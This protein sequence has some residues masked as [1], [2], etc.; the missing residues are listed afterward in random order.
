MNSKLPANMLN[1]AFW[2]SHDN[3]MNAGAVKDSHCK[4]YLKILSKL[5]E[6]SCEHSI[7]T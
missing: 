2:L 6:P 5:L 7:K 3:R 1:S 4:W